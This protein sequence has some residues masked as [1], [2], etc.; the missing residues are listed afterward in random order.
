[1][2]YSAKLKVQCCVVRR[3]VVNLQKLAA[4][5]ALTLC[6]LT[7]KSAS[8]TVSILAYDAESEV[9]GATV[10]SCLSPTS[11]DFKL[12]EVV[13]LEAQR[14]GVVAQSHFFEEGRDTVMRAL[15]AGSTAEQALLK[16]TNESFDP[17]ANGQGYAFRQYGVVDTNQESATF[18]GDSASPVALAIQG[19]GP[20]LSY[21]IAGNFLTN[22]QVVKTLERGLGEAETDL[23]QGFAL[24]LEA[25]LKDGGGDQRCA[26]RTSNRG[27]ATFMLSDGSSW[28]REVQSTTEDPAALLIQALNDQTFL[29]VG[30]PHEEDEPSATE[31]S[32][33]QLGHGAGRFSE[34]LDWLMAEGLLLLAIWRRGRIDMTA[35]RPGAPRGAKGSENASAR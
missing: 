31:N 32:G 8:A 33:C 23:A 9:L 27:Y 16:V 6:L 28:Q 20:L 35:G 24:A 7:T 17:E 25:L 34:P 4:A 2:G 10:I 11:S 5:L 21:V 15:K 18:T 14:G 26:P 19:K 30:D 12:A 29:R 1:M 22:E 3:G 13:R